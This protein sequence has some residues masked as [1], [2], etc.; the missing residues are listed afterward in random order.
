MATHGHGLTLVGSTSGTIAEI[1]TIEVAGQ[2]RDALDVSSM[3]STDK[4]REFIAGMADAGE[5]TFQLNYDGSSGGEANALNTA[6]QSGAIETWTATIVDTSVF[7][8][9]GFI[10]NLGL[11]VDFEGKMVQPVTVKL[12]VKS[13]FKDVA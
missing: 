8:C 13:T 12:S 5:L 10:T 6:Y 2:T 7:A 1:L 9:L 11:P 4:F 3:D